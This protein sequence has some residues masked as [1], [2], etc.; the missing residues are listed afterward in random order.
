MLD[1]SLTVWPPIVWVQ[2]NRHIL[3]LGA[4]FVLAAFFRFWAAPLS[5]GPD[6]AQFWAFA[7]A[8]HEHGLDFYQYADATGEGFPYWG[9]GYVYPP[10]WL[11][12]LG[13]ARFAAPSSFASTEVI[14]TSWR[15]AAKTPI[16][17]ADLAIGALIYWA[18]PGSRTRKLIFASLWLFHP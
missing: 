3:L 1:R 16:I 18:V 7:D 6:V 8:F 11:L 5:S 2:R 15:V 12:I 14:D 10:V 17:M 4:V 9:W 13:I